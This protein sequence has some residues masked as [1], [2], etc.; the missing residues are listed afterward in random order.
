MKKIIVTL[1]LAFIPL[2]SLYA[3]T[4]NWQGFYLGGSIGGAVNGDSDW[5]YSTGSEPT[6]N[7]VKTTGLVGGGALQYQYQIKNIV[8]GFE[9]KLLAAD[10]KGN[11]TCPNTAWNCRVELSSLLYLGPKLGYAYENFQI[12]GTAG[13]AQ[14]RVKSIATTPG[15][16][17]EIANKNN[18]GYGLGLGLDYAK[19]QN[20]IFGLQYLHVDL[21]R[22]RFNVYNGANRDV[23]NTSDYILGNISYKF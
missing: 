10:V 6:P 12:Y 14:A 16:E 4:Y 5:K 23:D 7:P 17:S 21:S 20:L 8:L 19:N 3:E 2:S 15:V 18:D 1:L 13:Y 9:A 22:E 11:S